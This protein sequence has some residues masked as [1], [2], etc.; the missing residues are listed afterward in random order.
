VSVCPYSHPDNLLHN[1]VRSGLK[2]SSLFRTAALKM[3]DY[4]YGRKP[5][6]APLPEWMKIKQKT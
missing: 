1:I 5:A 6:S 3:D 4:F 2:N